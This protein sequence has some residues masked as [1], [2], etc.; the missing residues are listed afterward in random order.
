MTRYVCEE[1]G[2]VDGEC[3]CRPRPP[4]RLSGGPSL[5]ERVTEGVPP[6]KPGDVDIR[7][8]DPAAHGADKPTDKGK[9][10]PPMRPGDAVW[11]LLK[12]RLP[13]LQAWADGFAL[14]AV[15]GDSYGDWWCAYSDGAGQWF[16]ARF[17]PA[18]IHPR[19]PAA[20]GA[21]RPDAEVG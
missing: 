19:A 6:M 7:R 5:C 16:I 2:E 1:C 14:G 3:K 8:R 18:G 20:H 15:L 21:D 13:P 10:V 17:A 4:L 11:V 12:P 9:G